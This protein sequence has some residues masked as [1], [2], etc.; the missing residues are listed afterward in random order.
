MNE[1]EAEEEGE[2]LGAEAGVEAELVVDYSSLRSVIRMGMEALLWPG[3][4]SIA[5]RMLLMSSRNR[6][7]MRRILGLKAIEDGGGR[8]GGGVG[9]GVGRKA[10]GS[11]I[12]EAVEEEEDEDPVWWRNTI[13]GC[14]VVMIKDGLGTMERVLRM[15]KLR[16]RRIIEETQEEED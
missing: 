1:E 13:G 3:I 15:R 9:V 7:W 6:G 10:L 8:V 11:W 5:G 16:D 2:N 4:G 12:F 14:M